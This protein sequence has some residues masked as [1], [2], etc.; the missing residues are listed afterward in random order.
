M[1]LRP[2]QQESSIVNLGQINFGP[3]AETSFLRSQV[4]M[5]AM[6]IA[7]LEAEVAEL[8]SQRNQLRA[9]L[10]GCAALTPAVSDA[11]HQALLQTDPRNLH[12]PQEK[13]LP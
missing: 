1:A 9:A 4:A 7:D 2:P 8:I 13:A 12:P 3:T 5:Q 11:K 6:E 10:Q